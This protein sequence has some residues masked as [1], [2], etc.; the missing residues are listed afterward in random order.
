MRMIHTSDW[1]LGRLFHGIHLTEDQAY[2]LDQLIDLIREEKPHVILVSGDIFD[3]SVPPTEAV[4]L[5]DDVVSK[6]LMDYHVPMIMIAGNHDSPDRLGFGCRLMQE[7]GL[8]LVGKLSRELNPIV[9]HDEHG[10]VYFHA[11]PYVEPAMVRDQLGDENIHVHDQSMMKLLHHVKGKMDPQKRHVLVAH[12]FVAGGEESESERPLSVG[13][14]GAVNPS[15]FRDFHYVALGHL[16]RPQRVGGE[17]IRYSGS[18]MKYS[19][20]EANHRKHISMIEMDSEGKIEV[21]HIELKPKRDLRCIEGY[22][23]EILRGPKAGENREDYLMVTLKDEGALL[24]PM[25][26]LRKV[27]PNVLHIERPQ[28]LTGGKGIRPEGNFRKMGEEDLFASFLKQV[29][30][31]E[32]TEGQKA[33]FAKILDQYYSM[34]KEG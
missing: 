28:L 21:Q 20:S 34:M 3:R 10:P 24:D 11:L 6:I 30:G 2:I 8:H 13:G 15:Y 27:Y 5:L 9:I 1:H 18:L 12:A 23:E 22:L 25:G 19:F 16:H 7:K 31:Q 14:S 32:I 4:N 33:I 26:K 29:T 17:N